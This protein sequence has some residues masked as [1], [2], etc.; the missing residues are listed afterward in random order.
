M[1]AESDATTLAK[2]LADAGDLFARSPLRWEDMVR[3]AVAA[4]RA[5]VPADRRVA[6][7]FDTMLSTRY[8]TTDP[9][10]DAGAV[11]D[12]VAALDRARADLF[13]VLRA[14]LGEDALHEVAPQLDVRKPDLNETGGA[15]SPM[16]LVRDDD[17]RMMVPDYVADDPVLLMTVFSEEK[18]RVSRLMG[19]DFGPDAAYPDHYR[20]CVTRTSGDPEDCDCLSGSGDGRPKRMAVAADGLRLV[21]ED[22]DRLVPESDPTGGGM[23]PEHWRERYGALRE[24]FMPGSADPWLRLDRVWVLAEVRRN[25]EAAPFLRREAMSN[26]RGDYWWVRGGLSYPWDVLNRVPLVSDVVGPTS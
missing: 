6:Q 23:D 26:A 11:V 19:G 2:A 20:G 8:G 14:W 7:A 10:G 3:E 25:P 22:S 4:L 21:V 16:M 13:R 18:R 12:A 5:T 24:L 9:D 15:P 17:F 1:S